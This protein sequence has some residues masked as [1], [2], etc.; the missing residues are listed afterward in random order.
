MPSVNVL[1]DPAYRVVSV[2]PA[3]RGVAWLRA[4]VARFSEGEVH[5]RRRALAEA[6][7]AEIDLT[8]LRR[9]GAPTATLA[10][11]L[12]LPRDPALVTDVAAVARSYQ[13]HAEQSPAADAAL[14]RL[15]ERCGGAHDEATAA[16]IG[17]LVQAHDAT[18]ALVAGVVPPVPATRRIAPDGHEVRVDL[19]GTPFGTGRH[20]CPGEPHAHALVDGALAFH[21]LHAGPTP[22]VLP[23]AWDVASALAFVAAGFPAVGTTSLGVAIAAGQPDAAGATAAETIA[24]ARR[25]AALP[26]PVT[27][28]IEAGFGRD[29]AD[30]AAELS[31]YGVAGVNIEDGRGS[32]LAD[33]DT[34]AA[35]VAELK[36]GAPELFVNARVDSYW[37]GADVAST[38]ARAERYVAVGADGVFVPG[39]SDLAEI[40]RLAG[41]LDVPLNVLAQRPLAEL[42]AAGVRRVSTG[43]LL[44]RSA[45]AAAVDVAR[46]VRAGDLVTADLTYADA[47]AYTL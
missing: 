17:L 30:L 11:A 3:Q 14:K 24:L 21:R 43:S 34:Q 26:V 37:I 28:D 44:V 23:N 16:R 42:A 39:L 38:R 46:R 22:L 45:L 47:A 20:A 12:G 5:R 25:L 32:S 40:E 7:L 9:P 6:L 35:L 31:A 2:P 18:A 19:T 33:P 15:V 8:A 13:P 4:S 29:P 36:R 1:E 41:A 27:V 10:A